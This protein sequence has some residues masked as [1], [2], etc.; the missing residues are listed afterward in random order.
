MTY[1]YAWYHC[2]F[3]QCFILICISGIR[4]NMDIPNDQ[5]ERWKIKRKQTFIGYIIVGAAI[6]LDYT[7]M[8]NTL[9]P[10]LQ[11][12]IKTK[13]P[14]LF[15][16]VIIATYSLS[17]TLCG[18]FFGRWVDKTRK[19]KY[20]TL[21]IIFLQIIGNLIYVIPF[22][23]FYPLIG[24]LLCGIGDPFAS[25][26]S[27]EIVRIYENETSTRAL[28]WLASVYG[29]GQITSP[30]L[31]F[32]FGHVDFYKYSIHVTR[33]NAVPLFLVF[34]LLLSFVAVFFLVHDCSAEIDLK[35]YYNE[36]EKRCEENSLL[37]STEDECEEDREREREQECLLQQNDSIQNSSCFYTPP[38]KLLLKAYVRNVDIALM[39][40]STFLFMYNAFSCEVLLPLIAL[41]L[42][43]LTLNTLSSIMILYGVILMLFYVVMA[44][45]CIGEQAVYTSALIS[46]LMQMLMY[47]LMITLKMTSRDKTRDLIIVCFFVVCFSVAWFIE[48][49][50]IR[51]ML[52]KMVPSN[53]QSFTETIRNG[54]SRTSTVIASLTAP[55]VIP[56]LQWWS[57]VFLVLTFM[58]FVFFILRRRSLIHIKQIE[59]VDENRW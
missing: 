26:I 25:V 58:C 38:I 23:V 40:T 53:C 1:H 24:R 13:W 16:G 52:A 20:Y 21:F 27:G 7:F 35:Q 3:S 43:C 12:M 5:L 46:I 14:R 44:K 18:V 22:N 41:N 56:F 29:I 4:R 37:N 54:C 50:L 32:I 36:A 17:S 28:W 48:E 31:I 39:L 15:Y 2:I 42:L 10:Y 49:V 8:F 59:I 47:C 19:I 11:D 51:C 9:F 34:L 33:L 45:Y 55:L 6:G 30:G 57:A